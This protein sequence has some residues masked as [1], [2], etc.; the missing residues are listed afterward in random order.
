M[1]ARQ[2]KPGPFADYL[3]THYGKLIKSHLQG[4]GNLGRDDL[5]YLV[6]KLAAMKDERLKSCVATLIGWGDEERAEVETFCA[7]ALE[8]MRTTPP[9][10][11]HAAAR[12]VEIKS[13]SASHPG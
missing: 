2:S 9:S 11:L 8:V 10:R 1:N 5:E 12:L 4:R 13:L 6:D 3:V 7:I